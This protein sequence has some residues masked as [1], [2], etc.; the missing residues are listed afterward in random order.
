M[1]KNIRYLFLFI[2]SY[3]FLPLHAYTIK[4]IQAEYR[5][6]FRAHVQKYNGREYVQKEIIELPAE[7]FLSGLVNQNKLYIN[8]ILTNYC[9]V[10]YKQ[11][12][13]LKGDTV[14]LS[15][16]YI[17]SLVQDKTFNKYFLEAVNCFLGSKNKKIDDYVS[18]DKLKISADSL[19]TIASK[20]FFATK[21][22]DDGFV[23]W[24]VC[25]GFNGYQNQNKQTMIPLIEAFSF[26][27]VFNNLDN[28]NFNFMLDFNNNKKNLEKESANFNNEE[29]LNYTRNNMYALMSKSESLKRLLIQEYQKKENILNFKIIN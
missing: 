15:E 29:K 16:Y 17:N 8:Y 5:N 26:M 23:L 20:F 27:T 4:D 10:D 18:S 28:E 22:K 7:H 9:E 25:V 19:I 2:S 3:Y 14:Q 24:H 21:I 1:W 11:L 13:N 6:I 12:N